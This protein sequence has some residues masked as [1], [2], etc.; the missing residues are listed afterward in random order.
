[1]SGVASFGHYLKILRSERG[2]SLR[3]LEKQVGISHNTLALYEK[4]RTVPSVENGFIL[5][6]FF[7]V[8]L[9]YFLKGEAVTSDFRDATLRELCKHVDALDDADRSLAKNYLTRLVKYRSERNR[10]IEESE[11]H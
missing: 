2:I 8:P 7:G 6:E 10:L 4:E 11:G 5:A 3:E 1:M 9:E